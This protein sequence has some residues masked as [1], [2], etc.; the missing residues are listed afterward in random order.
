VIVFLFA[1]WPYLGPK[2]LAFGLRRL[3][4]Q[5]FTSDSFRVL[6]VGNANLL[7]IICSEIEVPVDDNCTHI[8]VVNELFR[9]AELWRSQGRIYHA[10]FIS[11]RFVHES[12]AFM[13]MMHGRPL[14]MAVELFILNPIRG[15]EELL[16]AYEDALA[17][18]GGRPH[19]GQFNK[20]AGDHATLS[21]LYPQFPVWR[22][23]HRQLNSTGVFGSPMTK[24]VG[25]THLGAV[26]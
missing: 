26:L 8:E 2:L 15:S 1:S 23:V 9:T 6:N 14:T 24:R 7:P 10:G 18:F 22:A 20:V 13:S 5:D 21:A 3:A 4:N 16:S 17:Q 19:W 11:L 25:F 12:P